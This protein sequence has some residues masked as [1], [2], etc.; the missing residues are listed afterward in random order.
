MMSLD[1]SEV[2]FVR[3][4]L[5][6]LFF[7]CM[8]KS[9]GFWILPK[10]EANPKKVRFLTVLQGFLGG[11]MVTCG[12]SSVTLMPLGDA[13]TLIFTAP[14]TTMVFAAIFLRHRF[15]LYR[16]LNG[17]ILI[18]GAI[19]VIRP[20]FIFDNLNYNVKND[21][22]TRKFNNTLVV[23]FGQVHEDRFTVNYHNHYYYIGAAIALSSTVCNGF[24]NITISCCTQVKS[25][26]L[27][28]WA[29]IG[30]IFASFVCFTFDPNAKM[31]SH[32]ILQIPYT[33]WIAY[34]GIAISG[35]T[36]F[37]CMTK[38]LKMVDPTLV[39]FLRSLEIVFG[40]IFQI[41]VM[42]QIPTVL[43][44]SGAGMVL[45][46]IIAVSLQ[47]FIMVYI[48]EKIRFLF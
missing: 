7:S 16:L 20:S 43:A 46:S 8:L 17:L 2:M 15:R 47:D 28:W 19:L 6:V 34:V 14:F 42:K 40:F 22:I 26:I 21:I 1:F 37:F 11:I 24:L 9:K 27:L 33:H 5:Q 25:M 44:L 4:T 31:L 12:V 29:G 38:A 13:M 35:M 30:S 18:S 36:G 32:E 23:L 3:G 45:I 48:P 41:A 10:V 39:A